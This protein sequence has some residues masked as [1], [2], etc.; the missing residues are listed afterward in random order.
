MGRTLDRVMAR[1]LVEAGYM[2]LPEYI[3]MFGDEA[4]EAYH[5]SPNTAPD[6]HCEHHQRSVSEKILEFFH[7]H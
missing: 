5:Q 6:L 1:A 7:L 3:A 4:E 2:P